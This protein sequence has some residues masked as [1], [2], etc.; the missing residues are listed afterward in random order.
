MI[1]VDPKGRRVLIFGHADGG[2]HLAAEQSRKN[3]EKDG[4]LNC[5]VIV[6]PRLTRGYRFWERTLPHF[7]L[8]EHELILIVDLMLNPKEPKRSFD[9]LADRATR[10]RD[11]FFVVIN[12]RLSKKVPRPPSNVFFTFTPTAFLCCYGL[13]SDLMV[14][15]AICEGDDDSVKHLITPV[16]R[17]R[18]FGVSRAAA[19]IAGLAGEQLMVLIQAGRWDLIESLADDPP[20]AHRRVRGVRVAD[21]PPS[22]ALTTARTESAVV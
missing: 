16:L 3:L 18:A 17:K 10:E 4:A 21:V 20:E 8:G 7:D 19:D 12:H 11:R 2:G 22:L 13:P 15:A 14:M 6:D 1:S 5:E 9:A